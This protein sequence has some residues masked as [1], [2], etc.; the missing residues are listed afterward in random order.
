MSSFHVECD[1]CCQTIVSAPI[2]LLSTPITLFISFLFLYRRRYSYCVENSS[3]NH[4]PRVS[5]YLLISYFSILTHFSARLIHVYIYL[6]TFTF[7]TMLP[8]RP[9]VTYKYGNKITLESYDINDIL[10]VEIMCC[11]LRV[12]K[13][14]YD[15]IHNGTDTLVMLVSR[16]SKYRFL[17]TKSPDPVDLSTWHLVPP[18]VTIERGSLRGD[19]PRGTTSQASDPSS[20]RAPA[21]TWGL[22]IALG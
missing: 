11:L 22:K 18:E 9:I 15:R 2:P 8:Y 19:G 4:L 21:T 3:S 1:T 5:D 20:G 16:K 12:R 6:T 17:T 7:F 13:K 14:K 10:S